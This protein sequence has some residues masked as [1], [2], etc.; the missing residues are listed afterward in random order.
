MSPPIFYLPGHWRK[1]SLPIAPDRSLRGL[2]AFRWIHCWHFVDLLRSKE[3][4]DGAFDSV[5]TVLASL[6]HEVLI[7]VFCGSGG[8]V[9]KP[10]RD[11]EH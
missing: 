1:V 5:G 10:S 11:G 4:L 8:G 6:R 7:D 2:S 3:A 9:P